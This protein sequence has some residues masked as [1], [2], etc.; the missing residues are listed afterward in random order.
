M[1]NLS[2][3]LKKNSFL[4]KPIYVTGLSLKGLMSAPFEVQ[5]EQILQWVLTFRIN[6][7]LP[8]SF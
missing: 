4:T 6:S 1:R 8:V 2:Q 5:A 3:L 7:L